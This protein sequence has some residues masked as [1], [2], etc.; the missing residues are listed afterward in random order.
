METSTCVVEG[1]IAVGSVMVAEAVVVHPFASVT[2]TEFVPANRPV[3]SSV[4]C[5]PLHE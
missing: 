2:V 5:P 4:V 1:E 3:R